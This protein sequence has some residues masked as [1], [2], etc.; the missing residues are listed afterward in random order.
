MKKNLSLLLLLSHFIGSAQI[1]MNLYEGA[2]P[3]SKNI[4]VKEVSDNRNITFIRKISTPE[5][6][7]YLPTQVKKT[8]KAVIICPG[9]G[10]GGLAIDHE[11]HLIAKKLNE[12]GIAGIVLKYRCPD[13]EIVS[14]KTKVPLMDAQRAIQ[15]VRQHA[16]EWKIKYIGIMG[17]S[18]GG[19]LASTVA[20]HYN[21]VEIE[22]KEGNNLRPDFVI[23]PM[24]W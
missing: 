16:K 4:D 10:Y 5:I 21:Q 11:G 7:V 8:G 13:N 19:H 20:T 18:A 6:F 2:I 15:I 1:K 12:F 23:S 24:I 22:N 3:H 17:S 14:N 9:G